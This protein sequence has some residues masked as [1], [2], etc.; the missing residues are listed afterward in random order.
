MGSWKIW[1]LTLIYFCLQI[2]VHGTTFYL[3]EQ[4]SGLIGQDVGCQVGLISAVP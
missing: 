2:A 3:P 4:V 1:Y